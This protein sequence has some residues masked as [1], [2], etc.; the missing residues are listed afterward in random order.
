M[1]IPV[2]FRCKT[3]GEGFIELILTEDEKEKLKLENKRGGPIQC[4][5]CGSFDVERVS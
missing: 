2:G 3:C 5:T 4:K 1:P